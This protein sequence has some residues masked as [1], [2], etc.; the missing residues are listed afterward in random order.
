MDAGALL[1]LFLI[2]AIFVLWLLFWGPKAKEARAEQ[3][4][5]T[6]AARIEQERQVAAVRAERERQATSARA[7]QERQIATARLERERRD[8][9]DRARRDS[10]R[11]RLQA[12]RD[13]LLKSI[14]AGAPDFILR[15]RIDFEREYRSS[16]G[17]GMFG[18]EMSP[19]VCFGYRVGKTNGRTETERRAILEYAV[20][21]DFD[22]TL[23]FLPASYR[24]DWGKALSIMRFNRIY[25]HLNNM[26]DLRDGR[27]S[28]AVAV[29]HWRADAS[30]FQM[31][32]GPRVVKYR[33]L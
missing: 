12:E 18:Q 17:E 9:E 14:R 30:W 21:S 33:D 3:E 26:A 22:A 25:Q 20:A 5:Q 29:S 27:P 4:R 6:A 23:P 32:Q 31:Q 1:I 8:A 16:G 10:D 7:E 11:T 24:N 19:L 15:A 2:G 28:Y 13:N